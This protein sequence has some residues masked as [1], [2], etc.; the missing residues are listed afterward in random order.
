FHS[1]KSGQKIIEFRL[2]DEKR[3]EVEMGDVIVFKREPEQAETVR[4]EVIGLLRYRTFIDLASD[5]SASC[6]GHADKEDLLKSIY[7]FYTKEQEQQ[8]GVLGIRIRLTI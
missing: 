2:Y 8:Y 7:T 3:R 1:I 6:F 5:F 4:A